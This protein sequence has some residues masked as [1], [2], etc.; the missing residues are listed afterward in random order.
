MKRIALLI[1]II[2]FTSACATNSK[3]R[4]ALMGA[5][6][7]VGGAFG[8]STAPDDEKPAA[9]AFLW[10]AVFVSIAAIV[11]NYF[12]SDDKELEV[13]RAEK[14]KPNFEL[15]SEKEGKFYVPTGRL[16]EYSKG[17]YKVKKI[18]QWID[19]GPN[20]KVHQDMRLELIMPNEKKGNGSEK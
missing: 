3:T 8:Y 13:L 9:H 11:G 1:L 20:A 18:D 4:W 7:P 15:V 17:K 5:A 6:V 12:Y 2:S 16:G 19:E 14:N 10:S